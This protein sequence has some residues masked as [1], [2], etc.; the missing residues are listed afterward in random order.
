M[1]F[2]TIR[3]HTVY[4]PPLGPAA[5]VLDLGA[6]HGEF[7]RHMSERFGGRYYL[8]EANPALADRLRADARFRVWPCAVTPVDGPIAFHIARND[9]G[10]S[11]LDLPATSRYDCVLS[12]TVDIAGRT[13]ESLVAEI[14]AERIDLVKMDIEGAEVA[15][16]RTLPS[17][18]LRRIGQLTV[19]FHGDP[20]F[21]FALREQVEEVIRSLRRQGF[22][23][24][25]FTNRERLN[26]LCINLGVHRVPWPSRVRWSLETSPPIWLSRLGRMLPPSW[27]QAARR[28]LSRTAPARPASGMPDRSRDA[29]VPG[30]GVK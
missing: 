15:V 12:E 24:L 5:V 17:A 19:E 14:G 28:V 27:K 1:M 8:V 10:S 21:G 23:C 26:V 9:E 20:V 16:L 3:G 7:A 25:D 29:G 22:L 4:T 2:E 11:L 18:V 6:N 13:L 30:S